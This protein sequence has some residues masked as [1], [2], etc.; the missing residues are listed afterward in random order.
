MV[1]ISSRV[2]L[3]DVASKSGVSLMTASRVVNTPELVSEKTRRHVESVINELGYIKNDIASSLASSTYSNMFCFVIADRSCKEKQVIF[4][5]VEKIQNQGLI[6]CVIF[7]ESKDELASS[8]LRAKKISSSE[9]FIIL[10][11]PSKDIDKLLSDF[12]IIN[13]FDKSDTSPLSM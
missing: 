6:P 8:M 10:S 11:Y 2:R 12:K 13:L 7:F 1:D 3:Q 4:D 9:M 5:S